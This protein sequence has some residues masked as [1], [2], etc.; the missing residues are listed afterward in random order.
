MKKLFYTLLSILV[1]GAIVTFVVG[2]KL[3]Q[4]STTPDYNYGQNYDTAYAMVYRAY[5][6]MKPWHDSL[7]ENGLLKDTFIVNDHGLR[8]HGVYLEHP[9]TDSIATDGAIMIIHGYC[10]DAPVMMRYTYCCYEVLH[11]N[12]F[13]PERQWCG[14]SEGDHITF[15]WRDKDDM[16]LW[17][18]VMHQLWHK[19]I[20][21]HGLSMGAATTMMLSGDEIAD[22]LQ[23]EGFIED[24]G[25]SST[26]ELLESQLKSEYNLPTFPFLYAAS[27]VNKMWHGWW[28]SEGDAVAQ[29]AKCQK[30]MLFIHGTADE[31]VPFYM[32][33]QVY[34]AKT[35]A[36]T[37][38]EVPNTRH[39]KSI[40]KHWDE[41]CQ[42]LKDFILTIRPQAEPAAT[43]E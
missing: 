7:V 21:V 27:L 29:V 3:V 4:I 16:H 33:H 20:I 23:V 12:V 10:D 31:L 19:P 5:P 2:Y 28:F 6:E 11:Q 41:Y 42:T 32:V 36:K 25:Y 8:L 40:H 22:S 14:K 15:G 26:W 39:A 17:L 38:W 35:G 34:E 13:L 18:K 30:P 24:C 43:T 37:L 1:L 9:E